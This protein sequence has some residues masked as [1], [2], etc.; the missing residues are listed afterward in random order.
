MEELTHSLLENGSIQKKEDHY[1]LSKKLS[2]IQVP[3]T[4][5][6]IIAARIDRLD[7]SLKRIMHVASVIGREFA[8]R[9]LQSITEM[10]EELKAHL[11]NLQGLEFIYEKRLFP[12]LEYIFKHALTQEVAYNSLLLRR[13]QEIHGKIGHA[14][15]ELYPDRLEEFYEMLA[16]H[17][18]K[19]NDLEKAY[20]YLKLSGNKAV[21]SFSNREALLFYRDAASILRQ[22]PQTAESKRELLDLVLLMGVPI[23][24]LAYPEDPVELFQEGERLC[25]EL[26]D[27]KSLAT[28]Y[29]LIANFHAHKGNGALG[30]KYLEDAFR[31]GERIGDVEIMARVAPSLC[32]SYTIDSSYTK[33]VDIAP[34]VIALLEKT[35]REHESFG[36]PVNAYS[37]LHAFYGQAMGG[38]GEFTEGERLCEKSLSFAREINH[39][40][41][42]GQVEVA[43][44]IFFAQKGDGENAVKHF[45]SAIECFEKSHARIILPLTWGWL[46]WG[47]YL[48]GKLDSA[49][50]FI[51]KGLKMQGESGLPF[52]LSM[53]HYFLSRVRLDLGSL[54]EARLHAEEGLNLAR[55]NHQRGIEGMSWIQLGRIIGKTDTSQAAKAEEYILQGMKIFDELN[56]K[57]AY[58]S[59]CLALGEL[60]AG[61]GQKERALENLKKAET[62]FRE[63]GTDYWLVR[64][65]K[66]LESLETETS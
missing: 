59:G 52:L 45:R 35:H 21:K 37:A 15:E 7:E 50:E 54:S 53:Q 56:Q 62:M 43:Y 39:L 58:A 2:D 36:L 49:L 4:I 22:R 66:L 40:F 10:K 51:E 41:S 29:N 65:K 16:Y 64:T 24:Y 12:E 47:Y 11:L 1:I 44:G 46:G 57:P 20:G 26:G 61:V 48:S 34:H 23:E 38:L 60:Y 18:S 8:F 42:I 27:R 5:Q 6:G 25:E 14:I 33:I 31:E 28:L 30:R 17:Y 9:I 63:M 3:D 19:S 13:R 55:T 32:S